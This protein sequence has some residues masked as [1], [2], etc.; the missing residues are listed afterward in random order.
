ME[1]FKK[2]TNQEKSFFEKHKTKILVGSGM[3][4]ACVTG[5][6]LFKPTMKMSVP[7][8]NR[9]DYFKKIDWDKYGQLGKVVQVEQRSTKSAWFEQVDGSDIRNIADL[10]KIGTDL[11]EAHG[12]IFNPE[13]EITGILLYT[14]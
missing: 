14:K 11:I 4:I 10:G 3:V 13:D 7:K 8:F 2:E 9:E 5:G 6:L 1:D 12:S